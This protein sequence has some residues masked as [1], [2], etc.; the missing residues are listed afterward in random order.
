M[1]LFDFSLRGS[2]PTTPN[3]FIQTPQQVAAQRQAAD[4]TLLGGSDS[5]PVQSPWQGAGRLAK[6]WRAL[7]A[8]VTF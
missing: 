8:Y 2:D 1:S 4:A 7:T 5:S 3:A 6:L